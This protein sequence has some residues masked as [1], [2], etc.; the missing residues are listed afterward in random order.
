MKYVFICILIFIF[1]CRSSENSAA[2]DGIYTASFEH[3]F[4]KTDDTLVLKK[5]N[6]GNG[7]YQIVRHS[8]VIKKMDGKTFPKEVLNDTWTLD[9]NPDKQTLTEVRNGKTLIWNSGNLTLQFGET[10]YKKIAN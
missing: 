8:G 4:A 5:A 3:E 1:S 2:L 9:Y 7:V 10:T 6:E